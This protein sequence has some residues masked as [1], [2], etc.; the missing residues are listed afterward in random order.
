MKRLARPLLLLSVLGLGAA[1]L[2]AQAPATLPKL[3]PPPR[4]AEEVYDPYHAE[5]ALEIGEFYLKKG[6]VDA[7]IDRFQEA[8]RLKHDFARPRL[9]LGQAYERKDEKRDALRYYREYVKI[10]PK[11]PD[12]AKV[13][14]RIEKLSAE[15]ER[16]NSSP[17]H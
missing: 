4:P 8:I 7:A 17:S 12:A 13:R 6:D 5:K 11:A 1:G 3:P 15:L 10:L 9:L 14:K 16:E 2:A